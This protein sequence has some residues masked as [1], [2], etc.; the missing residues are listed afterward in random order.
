MTG[1]L[2]SPPF[3]PQ[4]PLLIQYKRAALYAANL[5]A[6]HVFQL[7]D[8]EQLADSFVGVAQKL[9]REIHLHFEILMRFDTVARDAHDVAVE[10][11]EF[12]ISIAELLALGGAAWRVVFGVEINYQVSPGGFI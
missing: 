1:D 12:G 4:R 2:D 6:I 7:D 9:E 10:L 11:G 5:L 3:P 8:V